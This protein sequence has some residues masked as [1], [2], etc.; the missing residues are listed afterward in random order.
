MLTRATVTTW[1]VLLTA[2]CG[3]SPLAP[4][5]ILAPPP[6]PPASLQLTISGPTS[7]SENLL[8]LLVA[9]ARGSGVPGET[10]FL[11]TTAGTLTAPTVVTG[12]TGRAQVLLRTTTD[13]TV[14][15]QVRSFTATIDAVAYRAPEPPVFP[16]PPPPP[17]PPP[18]V[19]PPPPPPPPAP[20]LSVALTCTA[21][22]HG[23]PSPCNVTASYG[24]ATLLGTAIT[25]ADWDWGDGTQTNNVASPLATHTYGQAGVFPVFVSVTAT[26]VDG[27]KVA[28]TSRTLTIP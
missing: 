2:A 22:A 25:D 24:G 10:V 23:S 20:T 15:A 16:D 19:V 7:V 12:P 9:D 4:T 28:S 14:T 13:A 3:S 5:P 8:N 18:V 17:P 27:A 21:V 11:S 26:T 6:S 1:A